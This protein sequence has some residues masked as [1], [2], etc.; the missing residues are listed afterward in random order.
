LCG[1]AKNIDDV[2]KLKDGKKADMVF[3]DPPYGISIIKGNKGRI[4]LS[5]KYNAIIGDDKPFDPTF[6][7]NKAEK[8]I[9]FGGNYFA[10]KLPNSSCW[11][12]CLKKSMEV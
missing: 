9:I 4:G 12:I 5:K 10:N 8:I 7:L 11:L 1:D 6:L 3:T 2:K